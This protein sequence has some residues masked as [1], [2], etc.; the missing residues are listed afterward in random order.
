M[1]QDAT[2]LGKIVRSVKPPKADAILKLVTFS[3]HHVTSQARAPAAK[4]IAE[5]R[6]GICVPLATAVHTIAAHHAL[7]MLQVVYEEPLF[8]RRYG[9]IYQD[10]IICTIPSSVAIVP[11]L[12][13][14]L[15]IHLAI[16]KS[17]IDVIIIQWFCEPI[18]YRWNKW[19][20]SY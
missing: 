10:I 5:L 6:S 9:E 4:L 18:V 19:N 8:A 12:R 15:T 1:N 2:W 13:K 11:Y 20:A 17:G 7:A 16:P 3:Y 14:V